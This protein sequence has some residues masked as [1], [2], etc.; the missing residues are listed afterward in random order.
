MTEK[1]TFNRV[2]WALFAVPMSMLAAQ[3]ILVVIAGFFGWDTS[4]EW[5]TLLSSALPVYFCALPAGY[6]ILKRL[7]EDEKMGSSLSMKEILMFV[8]MCF[9]LI[10]GGSLLGSLL[11]SALSNGSAENP[12]S[13]LVFDASPWKL[14]ITVVLAPI[15]EEWFFRKELIGRT[16]RYGEKAAIIFSAA[17]FAL[18]HG[19]LFQLFYAFALGLLFG[20]IFVRTRNVKYTMLLHMFVN[21]TG[22]VVAPWVLSRTDMQALDQLSAGEL[23]EAA[24]VEA[25]TGLIPMLVYLALIMVL[26]L[27]GF[28]LL[29]AYAKSFVFLSTEDEL[30]GK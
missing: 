23:N 8:L 15:F 28:V 6:A 25:V 2:G 29:V 16:V 11:S 21:F 4:V 17:A 12:V 24:L 30:S 5:F 18:I 22:G 7:P 1:Q 9:P 13:D 26:S 14:A 19:N 10:Y 3:I 20:Y 27:V